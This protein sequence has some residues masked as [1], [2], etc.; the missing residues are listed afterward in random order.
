MKKIN[1]FQILF[2]LLFLFLIFGC[3]GFAWREG[4]E[5]LS[6][7][8]STTY[9]F[10]EREDEKSSS[11]SFSYEIGKTY[12]VPEFTTELCKQLGH[13]GYL[14]SGWIFYDKNGDG[15]PTNL[16]LNDSNYVTQFTVSYDSFSFYAADWDA[17]N[18]NYT[19]NH[20]QQNITDD[21]YTLCETQ[22]LTGKT[23]TQTQAIAK[24]YE[25]FTVQAFEQKNISGDG[26]TII[27]IYYDRVT[28]TILYYSGINNETTTTTKGRYGSTVSKIESPED[29][30]NADETILYKFTKWEPEVPSTFPSTDL[31]I[32]AIY[33][34]Y[35][36][37]IFDLDGGTISTTLTSDNG[38]YVESGT[39]F[40]IE[41]PTKSGYVFDYWKDS[42]G[43]KVTDKTVTGSMT[44]TAVW[45]KKSASGSA[46]E[47]YT[48]VSFTTTPNDGGTI[49]S[50]SYI[51]I[52]S[53]Q[54]LSNWNVSLYY[55][56]TSEVSCTILVAENA[57][58]AYV[59]NVLTKDIYIL[60]E[61]NWT[62]GSYSLTASG[63]YNNVGYSTEI[64]FTVQ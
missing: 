52:E 45:T 14:A 6:D 23:G 28:S 19:V 56:G 39:E 32:Y 2:S 1:H 36:K 13:E 60:V 20:Y 63:I 33:T 38:L 57:S 44:L 62:A 27:N 12:S 43:N 18:V 9:I 51:H 22:T 26:S 54:S 53:D 46:T 21:E 15:T 24:T 61:S 8:I 48:T 64:T 16:V 29:V 37:V 59:S 31:E 41:T 42:D 11:V 40:K 7:D 35:Y 10:Y 49:S 55:L 3:N 17:K 47:P 34:T 4:L 5:E 25:G 50:G 30:K 58:S